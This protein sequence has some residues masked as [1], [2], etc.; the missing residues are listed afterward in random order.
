MDETTSV[1]GYGL[2]SSPSNWQIL[3][4]RTF[5]TH[6]RKAYFDNL[7]CV[8]KVIKQL[9]S[10]SSIMSANYV[11]GQGLC[12][13]CWGRGEGKKCWKIL[14]I[15]EGFLGL[16]CAFDAG[17]TILQPHKT[18][19]CTQRKQKKWNREEN[20]P[21]LAGRARFWKKMDQLEEY[22]FLLVT[23]LEGEENI[24]WIWLLVLNG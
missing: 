4:N 9:T 23:L 17:W 8:L 3:F 20:G 11:G 21:W 7:K 1:L 22:T 13:K 15:N 18:P 24:S 10:C 6:C 12:W 5:G 14:G 2:L 19:E 16:V